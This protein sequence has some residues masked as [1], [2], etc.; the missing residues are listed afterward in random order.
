M[1]CD[2]SEVQPICDNDVIAVFVDKFLK[3]SEVFYFT[4]KV[5]S[6]M[7]SYLIL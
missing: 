6:Y 5:V 3:V 4:E 7:L 1:E 2:N